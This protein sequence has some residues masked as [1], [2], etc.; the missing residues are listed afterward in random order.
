[1]TESTEKKEILKIHPLRILFISFSSS[2]KSVDGRQRVSCYEPSNPSKSLS[3][4]DYRS[5]FSLLDF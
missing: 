4:S 2:S 5:L 3:S 1:M